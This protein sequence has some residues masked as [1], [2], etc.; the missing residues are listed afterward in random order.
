[1]KIYGKTYGQLAYQ[2]ELVNGVFFTSSIEYNQRQALTNQSDYSFTRTE[3]NTYLSNNPEAPRIFDPAFEDQEALLLELSLRF[4]YKQKYISY[5]KRKYIMGSPL[6]DLWID[7]RKGI[8]AFDSDV[9]FDQLRLRIKEN[10]LPIGIWGYLAFQLEAGTF[11]NKKAVPFIDAQHFNGNRTRIGVP[12][13]YNN[14]F[15][16]LPYYQYSTTSN[17]FEAHYQHHLEGYLLDKIPGVRS[18]GWTSVIGASFLYTEEEEDYL[19][20]SFGLDRLGFGLFRLFRF[21]LVAAHA[22][23]GDWNIGYVIGIKLPTN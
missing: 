7:Y 15:H 10:F 13:T 19:E 22:A 20:L 3:I 4:R 11:L 23:D 21:D 5:P 16:L 2:Q 14:S 8:S 12:Q 1:M 17:Y 18:L 6:P 9:N